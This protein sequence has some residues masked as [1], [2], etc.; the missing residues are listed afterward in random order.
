MPITVSLE[1]IES[2]LKTKEVEDADSDCFKV[3]SNAKA[4]PLLTK[5]IEDRQI[6]VDS[7]LQQVT[8]SR[9]KK[10]LNKEIKKAQ[11]RYN[12]EKVKVEKRE[13]KFL[14]RSEDQKT[15]LKEY[16]QALKKMETYEKKLQKQ[17]DIVK[18]KHKQETYTKATK[19]V[20]QRE[21]ELTQVKNEV[22]NKKLTIE[23]T[24]SNLATA[25]KDNCWR[26]SP[27]LDHGCVSRKNSLKTSLKSYEHDLESLKQTV[28]VSASALGRAKR[29]ELRAKKP[30]DKVDK[31][32]SELNKAK[33]LA[34]KKS[35]DLEYKNTQKDKAE[36][37]LNK[38][39]ELESQTEK[40][41]GHVK[42]ELE[43]IIS[44]K[45]DYE[46]ALEDLNELNNELIKIP[47]FIEE[48]LRNMGDEEEDDLV[49]VENDVVH[50]DKLFG[51]THDTKDEFGYEL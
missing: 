25:E 6:E 5:E 35:N 28:Q 9:R 21:K 26:S 51:E 20:K 18:N 50:N 13:K 8:K 7:L 36:E 47:E 49:T 10:Q 46:E 37:K 23:M 31:I 22:E 24:K 16:E 4:K 17:N 41:L 29:A 30:F 15:A 32:Y 14:E 40:K 34:S 44:L 39:K 11:R 3:L 38:A 19:G 43:D 1:K 42:G 33:R 45:K 27:E 2:C 48:Y 12:E